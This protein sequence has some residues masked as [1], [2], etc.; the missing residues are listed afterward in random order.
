[1]VSRANHGE[2]GARGEKY[3]RLTCRIHAGVWGGRGR[4][5][6]VLRALVQFK[7]NGTGMHFCFI[8]KHTLQKALRG[9]CKSKIQILVRVFLNLEIFRKKIPPHP[10]NKPQKKNPNSGVGDKE[11][12]TSTEGSECRVL[13]GAVSGR[14][15][16]GVRSCC[17]CC[18]LV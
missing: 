5:V 11:H 8:K 1:M 2:R 16:C 17:H 9:K 7:Q 3:S 4:E 12:V 18:P 13:C 15:G 14:G 6:L 10:P